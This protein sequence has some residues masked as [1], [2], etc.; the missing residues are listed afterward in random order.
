MANGRLRDTIA[1][2][3]MALRLIGGTSDIARIGPH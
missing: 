1:L 3:S 2:G